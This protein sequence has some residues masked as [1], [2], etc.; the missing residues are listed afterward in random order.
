MC[1]LPRSARLCGDVES[2]RSFCWIHVVICSPAWIYL[3]IWGY[4]LQPS[5][6]QSSIY[7][8]CVCA[9]AA[10]ET[11]WFR[12]PQY[13]YFTIICF[14]IDAF[15]RSPQ[16]HLNFVPE[17]TLS[18]IIVE[19]EHGILEDHFLCKQ[20]VF[21][22][23]MIISGSVCR[24]IEKHILPCLGV[25]HHFQAVHMCQFGHLVIGQLYKKAQYAWWIF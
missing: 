22:T 21:A 8:V 5:T 16:Q 7:G 14:G 9:Q 13:C 11:A 4:S 23:S 25:T 12:I 20:L 17:L 10:G 6:R 15:T 24:I 2:L 3:V 18:E 19:V 1:V